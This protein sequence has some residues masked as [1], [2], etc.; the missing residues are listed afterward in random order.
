MTMTSIRAESYDV[1]SNISFIEEFNAK[2]KKL[3]ADYNRAIAENKYERAI[4]VGIGILKELLEVARSHVIS[5]LRSIEVRGIV[6]DILAH[7]EK[8][9][10]Y[11]EGIEEA[12]SELPPLYSY[13]MRERAITAL[14]SSIQELFS[15]ILGALM[16]IVDI[17]SSSVNVRNS[18]N[19][20]E[21]NF[22]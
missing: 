22:I 6:E 9:L 15:F 11:V 1:L 19:F 8:N 2:I 13:E 14:S 4:E 16:V 21:M 12:I 18:N 7:H 20:D 3:Y 17:Y 5:N 10:G